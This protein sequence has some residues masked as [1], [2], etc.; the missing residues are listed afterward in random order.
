MRYLGNLPDT[1][2]L[3]ALSQCDYG[4]IFYTGEVA[5]YFANVMAA[6]LTTYLLAGLPIL[7]QRR[8]SSMAQFVERTGT[9]LVFDSIDEL[10]EIIELHRKDYAAMRQ[11][12]LEQIP[13]IRACRHY[14]D[15]LVQAGVMVSG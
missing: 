15:A 1:S 7:C 14:R 8:Y 3:P 5:D 10:P 11:R 13:A 9:G 12:C 2:L 4:F 6:K